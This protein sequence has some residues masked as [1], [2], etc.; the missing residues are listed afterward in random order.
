MGVAL[1]DPTGLDP[2]EAAGWAASM[3]R[4]IRQ[5]SKFVRQMKERI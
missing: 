4:S 2:G 3:D 1:A 5:L